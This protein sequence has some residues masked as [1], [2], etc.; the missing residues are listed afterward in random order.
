M[1]C[2][3][4]R[5]RMT[6]TG[7]LLAIRARRAMDCPVTVLPINEVAAVRQEVGHVLDKPLNADRAAGC[8]EVETR[9]GGQHE[10]DQ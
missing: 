10:E 3:A 4:A 1:P 6:T 5:Q 9:G 8:M 2:R 7:R